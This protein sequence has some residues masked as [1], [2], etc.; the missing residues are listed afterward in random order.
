MPNPV[1]KASQIKSTNALNKT[2]NHN[3]QGS[4]K[5]KTNGAAINPGL[6]QGEKSMQMLLAKLFHMMA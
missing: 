3:K 5:L 2:R 4:A 6:G 1:E